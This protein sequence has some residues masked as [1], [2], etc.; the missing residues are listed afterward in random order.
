[1][2]SYY[3]WNNYDRIWFSGPDQQEILVTINLRSDLKE[4][5]DTPEYLCSFK[6][7]ELMEQLD[8]QKKDLR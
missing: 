7:G 8:M 1:M 5:E 2:K 4:D 3:K 6:K